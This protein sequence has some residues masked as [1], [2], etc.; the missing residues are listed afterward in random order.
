MV[1]TRPCVFLLE[2]ELQRAELL[3]E[4]LHYGGVRPRG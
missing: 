4:A 1:R 3:L 2:V